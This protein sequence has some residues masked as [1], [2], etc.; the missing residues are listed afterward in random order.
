MCQAWLRI[1]LVQAG[2]DSSEMTVLQG[3]DAG[4]TNFNAEYLT[5]VRYR[6]NAGLGSSLLMTV[7]PST[8]FIN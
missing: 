6:I 8:L 2:E 3:K 7:L 1:S 5:L 4:S